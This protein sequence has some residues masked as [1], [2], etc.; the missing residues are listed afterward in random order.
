MANKDGMGLLRIIASLR[1]FL[2][3]YGV[4]LLLAM[5]IHAALIGLL[6]L[7]ITATPQPTAAKPIASY[8]YQPEVVVI[9]K[10]MPADATLQPIDNN[11][12][13]TSQ[14][15]IPAV[16][17]RNA[18][19]RAKPVTQ[20]QQPAPSALAEGKAAAGNAAESLADRAIRRAVSATADMAG[21]SYQQFISDQQQPKITVEKR[22][23]A[24]SADPAKQVVAQL[25]D[26]RQILRTKDGCQLS[27]PAKHGFD[28]LMAAKK[29][30]CGDEVSTDDLLKQALQ[31][32][33]K[34]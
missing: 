9:P 1:R 3:A 31:K 30:P 24:I 16:K 7:K 6:T 2:V 8:L 17:P 27:D 26:G 14:T 28:A 15:R 4:S 19:T 34:R 21:N 18:A 10:V 5:L 22:Y 11:Q 12:S 25:N 29:V 23:Q 13:H 20:E 32:H 33:S